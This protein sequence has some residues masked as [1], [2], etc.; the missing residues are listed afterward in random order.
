MEMTAF[1]NGDIREDINGFQI[2]FYV[3]DDPAYPLL[4]VLMKPFP[5]TANI[6]AKNKPVIPD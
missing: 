3:I 6:T 4:P 1:P 5:N 2:P